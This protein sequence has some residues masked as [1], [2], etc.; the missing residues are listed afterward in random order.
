MHP[1][2]SRAHPKMG[3]LN[4]HEAIAD[5]AVEADQGG[6][7]PTAGI[8]PAGITSAPIDPEASRSFRRT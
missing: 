2:D 1:P 3:A 6:P 7:P 5:V 4:R 8:L